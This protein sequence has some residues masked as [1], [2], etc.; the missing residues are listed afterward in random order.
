MRRV[1]MVT[2]GLLLLTS[3][4]QVAAQ[5]PTLPP[6]PVFTGSSLT[7]VT[8]QYEF[9][10][11]P[12]GQLY[13]QPGVGYVT[14]T[15]FCVR[16]LLSI[17]AAPFP[18]NLSV[19]SAVVQYA[20]A[21]NP[22][23]PN[24]LVFESPQSVTG[25]LTATSCPTGCAGSVVFSNFFF[26]GGLS[27]MSFPREIHGAGF[28]API[29]AGGSNVFVPQS[30]QTIISYPLPEPNGQPATVGLTATF[31][32]TQVALMVAPEP[33]T[34]MLMATGLLGVV[35]IARRKRNG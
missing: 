25:T 16:G 5:T 9:G 20:Y 27:Q 29:L 14:G 18:G 28:S 1:R 12:T 32:L 8:A 35:G 7:N 30:I 24:A 17:G 31:A 19:L 34:W 4:T 15:P 11:C 21:T 10:G 3:A 2:L 6:L 33:S 22:L 23:V 13:F 26:E